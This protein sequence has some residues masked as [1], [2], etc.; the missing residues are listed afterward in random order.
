MLRRLRPLLLQQRQQRSY[1]NIGSTVA[2]DATRVKE[3]QRYGRNLEVQ[4]L[5][6]DAQIF[7]RKGGAPL[8]ASALAF[9][10][11]RKVAGGQQVA[12]KEMLTKAMR[13]ELRA[14]G[15]DAIGKPWVV[16]ERLDQARSEAAELAGLEQSLG[17]ETAP[18][19]AVPASGAPSDE[20]DA[21]AAPDPPDAI[22]GGIAA[23][24]AAKLAAKRG[25]GASA[26]PTPGD[27]DLLSSAKALVEAADAQRNNEES[28]RWRMGPP[29]LKGLLTHAARRSMALAVVA[30]PDTTPR[31]LADLTSQAGVAFDVVADGEGG[32]DAAVDALGLA[33]HR[34]LAFVD[35][36][37]L[38]SQAKRCDLRT[39]QFVGENEELPVRRDRRPD[40]DVSACA[41]VVGVI[42]E[43]NGL[44]FRGGSAM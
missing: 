5:V 10:S 11:S 32:I 29:G 28:S 25:E 44:S 13:E 8:Q 37:A 7:R 41:D 23:K 3:L 1:N 26:T 14:R 42:D 15:L 24:Y 40:Y 21:S 17:V 18:A 9:D 6:V 30:R 43:L 38:L 20:P 12:S 4:A 19:E 2:P 36:S 34:V 39:V 31:E 27:A 33:P 16:R 22:T 35:D